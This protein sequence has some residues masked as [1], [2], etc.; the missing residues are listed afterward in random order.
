MAEKPIYTKV[1]SGGRTQVPSEVRERLDLR[2]GDI[3]VW[4]ITNAEARV[5]K[6]KIEKAI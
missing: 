1:H 5:F 6:A 2:D 3:L 4:E